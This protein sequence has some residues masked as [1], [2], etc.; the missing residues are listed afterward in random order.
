MT[1]FPTSDHLSGQIERVTYT[2]EENGYTVARIKVYGERELV[3]VVGNILDPAPGTILKM[4]GEWITHSRYGRQFKILSYETSV[5]ATV[6]GIE[7]YLGSGLIKGIGPVMAR[8]IVKFFGKDTLDVIEQTPERLGNVSGIGKQRVDMIREAWE[9]QKDIRDVMLFLQSQGISSG[10][11]SKIYKV[12]AKDSI[13]IVKSNPYRLAYD[14]RGIG[15]LT[16]DKIADKL[17]FARDS[18]QRAEAGLLFALH[19]LTDEG[20]VYYPQE[21]LLTNAMELLHIENDTLLRTALA[22]TV[23]EQRIVIDKNLAENGGEPAVYLAGYHRAEVQV[24]QRLLLLSQA[25]PSLRPVKIDAAIAWAEEKSGLTLAEQQKEAVRTALSKKVMV[26]TGGPGTGKTTILKTILSIYGAITTHILLAAPTGRAAKRMSEATNCE[27]KTLHRLLV[28][29]VR[30]GMFKKN[31]NDPLDCELLV[32]DEVSMVDLLLF[33]HL[34]K[35]VPPTAKLILVG[36]TDQ[37][38]SVGAGRVQ[39]DIIESKVIPVVRLNKIFRQAR[40]STIITNAHAIIGGQAIHFANSVN[41]DMFFITRGSPEEML[42]TIVQ[43]AKIRLPRTYHLDPLR[44]IQVLSPMNRGSVGTTRLNEA[45]QEALNPQGAQITR[46][47]RCF[48]VGDKV[49]Q[50]RNDYD[51]SVFN[52][53]IGII[54]YIDAENQELTVRIDGVDVKYDFGDLDELVLAYA[55]SIHKSQGAEYPAVIIPVTTQHYVMLQRNL[56]YTGVTRGKRLVVLV[57]SK[58]ALNIAIRNNKIMQRYTGLVR[59][60][61]GEESW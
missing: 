19:S 15:F 1:N 31:Q 48:R 29:D 32:L 17:G 18:P 43:I 2:N 41:D 51:R 53:D 26:I 55:I 46:G 49:M 3:T 21:K 7:K 24:A 47:G 34:L 56:L 27:A 25:M 9:E 33:H 58:K 42:E 60:L 30:R 37:L 35:A 22:H 8:R 61:G 59:R 57:G 38:P 50:I 4:T 12:Y 39:Q 44:D 5:P 20:H 16:A 36:D 45:L 14:I 6:H 23:E 54:V 10:Y 40:Q 13:N 11:A 52:G 28:Y